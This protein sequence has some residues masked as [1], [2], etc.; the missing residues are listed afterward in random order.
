MEFFRGDPPAVAGIIVPQVVSVA[1][2]VA[3][4]ASLVVLRR[5]VWRIQQPAAG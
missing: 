2:V 1:L 4:L 3:A 5:S